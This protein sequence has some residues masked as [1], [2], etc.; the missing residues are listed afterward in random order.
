MRAKVRQT[1]AKIEKLKMPLRVALVEDNARTRK[2]L[3][4]LLESD[5]GIKCVAACESADEAMRVIPECRP[6]VVLMDINLPGISGIE[7]TAVL[8]ARLPETQVLMLTAY[9]DNDYVFEALKAG[10]SGYLLK[11]VAPED[12]L[13]SIRE[14]IAGGA[15]MNGM[16]ARQVIEVFRK[17]AGGS[18][19]A[20]LTT[21]ENEILG[22]LAQ[23]YSN[24]EIAARLA[25][26]TGTVSVH[27]E[28]IYAKLHV[29]CRTEAAA[30]YLGGPTIP[31]R[32]SARTG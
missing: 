15:P 32:P 29:R 31:P 10:A 11:S 6:Q 19:E 26:G 25:L 27:L 16:I 18:A 5:P 24:K 2:G 13:D 20:L 9:S 17:P 14:V 30:K 1:M 7:C 21:R 23:G 12:L 22:L 4:Q 28:H 3:A 8:K